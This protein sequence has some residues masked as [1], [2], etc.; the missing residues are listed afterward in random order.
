M[1]HWISLGLISVFKFLFLIWDASD[2]LMSI[3]LVSE[4]LMAL[5]KRVPVCHV[6]R[7]HNH[8]TAKCQLSGGGLQGGVEGGIEGPAIRREREGLVGC[9]RESGEG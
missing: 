2:V 7:W 3:V 9:Q 4:H 5:A 1:I 8:V 6:G